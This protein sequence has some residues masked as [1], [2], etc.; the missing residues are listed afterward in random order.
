MESNGTEQDYP[1]LLSASSKLQNEPWQHADIL[2]T[3]M[4]SA[5]HY[6]NEW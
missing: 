6:R 1:E 2:K 3:I 5:L 4:R